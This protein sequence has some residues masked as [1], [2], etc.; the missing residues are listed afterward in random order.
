MNIEKGG[1]NLPVCRDARQGVAHLLPT[2]VLR[3]FTDG[4]ERG[5]WVTEIEPEHYWEKHKLRD[6]S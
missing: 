3:T 5:V 6:K 2:F 4:L 1:A